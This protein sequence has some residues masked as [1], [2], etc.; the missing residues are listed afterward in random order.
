MKTY[1]TSLGVNEKQIT[2][3]KVWYHNQLE[4]INILKNLKIK[5]AGEESLIILVQM[6]TASD[7]LKNNFSL[8]YNV[9]PLLII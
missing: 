2:S 9:K 7:I 6:Q 1:S 4:W 5:N 3:I 8:S